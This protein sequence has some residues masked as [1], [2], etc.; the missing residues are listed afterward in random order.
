MD[1]YISFQ[2]GGCMPFTLPLRS[3]APNFSLQGTD[4]KQYSLKSFVDFPVLVIFFTC[5]HC[6]YVIASDETTRKIALKYKDKGVAFVAINSNTP[7]LYDEDSFEHMVERMKENK[8]PWVY[9]VD[10]TQEVARAYG[11]LRTPH[12]FIFDSQRQLVYCGC[13]LDDPLHPK[14][15]SRNYIDEAL[16]EMLA[17]KP[18]TT[19][20]TNPVGCT[21]KWKGHYAHWMPEDACDLV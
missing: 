21:V 12:F 15:T 2:N 18:V 14:E 3:K 16:K 4:G 13:E 10:S 17:K 1:T 19:A 5:N 8:F 11:A 6:P 20:L 7:E 9:L